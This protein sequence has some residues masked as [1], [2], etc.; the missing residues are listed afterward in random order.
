MFDA[1]DGETIFVYDIT[2]RTENTLEKFNKGRSKSDINLRD[3][4]PFYNKFGFVVD[5][6]VHRQHEEYI[7]PGTVPMEARK[8]CLQIFLRLA[9]NNDVANL[10]YSTLF[11]I[12]F[13][14]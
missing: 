9:K 5:E 7:S 10:M 14:Q 4:I 11:Y 12:H 2:D 3:T 13:I 6:N 8:T 1:A